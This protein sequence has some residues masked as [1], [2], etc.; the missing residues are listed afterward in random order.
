[1]VGISYWNKEDVKQLQM[2]IKKYFIDENLT[3]LYWDEV[4]LKYAKSNYKLNV[5]ECKISD[6]IEIDT[7]NE[8]KAIDPS[9]K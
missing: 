5:R 1:M 6:I 2:D 3:N 4:P 7:Y 9:Y 8:L